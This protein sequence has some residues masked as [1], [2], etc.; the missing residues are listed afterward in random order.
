MEHALDVADSYG[1]P[2]VLKGL[3]PHKIHKTELG[4]VKLN[5]RDAPEMASVFKELSSALGQNGRITDFRNT[6]TQIVN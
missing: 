6:S 5:L 3:I 4:L 2:V 1:Y